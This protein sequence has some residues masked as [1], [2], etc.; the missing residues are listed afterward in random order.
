MQ[1]E[2]FTILANTEELHWWPRARRKIIKDILATLYPP[3]TDTH[4]IDVGCGVGGMLGYLSQWY[5]C[6]GIDVA[7]DA[8]T[9]ARTQFPRVSF[10]HGDIQQDASQYLHQADIVLL[11]DVIEHIHDDKAFIQH[12]ST[13]MQRDATLLITVPADMRLW[14]QHDTSAA[15]YRRYSKQ[16]LSDLIQ[17]ASLEV[18]FLSYYN[19]NL[20]PLIKCARA[21]GNVL[22]RSW[23]RSGLDLHLPPTPINAL[24][25]RIFSSEADVLCD[26]M[27]K[28]RS[29][30][31]RHGVSLLAVARKRGS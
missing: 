10:V 6:T 4:I 9:H 23:G 17:E 29:R 18:V 30:P 19:Y 11:C 3:S 31:I 16:Q 20:Y 21:L 5:S 27:Q 22:Q 13:H 1:P 7:E 12:L 26:L 8:I 2:H 15:H 28:K 14:S 25:Y 24:L